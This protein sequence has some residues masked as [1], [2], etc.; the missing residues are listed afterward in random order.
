MPSS[1]CF[2]VINAF[3]TSVYLEAPLLQNVPHTVVRGC[4]EMCISASPV[5]QVD[6]TGFLARSRTRSFNSSMSSGGPFSPITE[7]HGEENMSEGLC[8]SGFCSLYM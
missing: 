7:D 8:T 2:I 6:L 1:V 3:Y 4:E 5:D